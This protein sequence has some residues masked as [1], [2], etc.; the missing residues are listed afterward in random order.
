[1]QCSQIAISQEG[2]K[3]LKCDKECR[4]MSPR[5]PACENLEEKT[6]ICWPVNGLKRLKV[7][8]KQIKREQKG[9]FHQ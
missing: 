4:A 2:L 1:M 7:C 8:W 6:C 5:M 9:Q 3:Q